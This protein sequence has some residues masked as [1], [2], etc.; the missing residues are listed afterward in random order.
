MG[1]LVSKPKTPAPARIQYVS[2][3]SVNTSSPTSTTNTAGSPVTSDTSSAA[4]SDGLSAQDS[5]A[6]RAE[7][8]ARR[9]RGRSGTVKT[10]FNGLLAINQIAPS[11]KSLLGE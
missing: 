3:P 10:G 8:I 4:E 11:R 6:L 7:N 2:V 1:S 5:S 9:A